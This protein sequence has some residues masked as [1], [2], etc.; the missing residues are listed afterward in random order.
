MVRNGPT[1][2]RLVDQG[3]QIIYA[4]HCNSTGGTT[5]GWYKFRSA[6]AGSSGWIAELKVH[7]ALVNNAGLFNPDLNAPS[8]K[9]TNAGWASGA[10]FIGPDD[11]TLGQML[12]SPD[13]SDSKENVLIF[14]IPLAGR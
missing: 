5:A 7:A 2:R 4:P 8:L 13:K 3:A 6:W 9:D 11:A 10:W 14:N 1:C 12:E